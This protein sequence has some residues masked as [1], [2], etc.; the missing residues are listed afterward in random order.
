MGKSKGSRIVVTLECV[1][2]NQEKNKF[3]K[4]GVMRYSTSKN[5]RNT[6]N[7]LEINKFCPQCNQH[8]LFKEIK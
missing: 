8:S 4:N 1:C 3:R 6:P 5:K 2:K 7:R